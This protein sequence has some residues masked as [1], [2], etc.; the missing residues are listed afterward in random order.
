MLPQRSQ[1]ELNFRL[2]DHHVHVSLFPIGESLQAVLICLRF[3]FSRAFSGQQCG[4]F[5]ALP[6]A[7]QPS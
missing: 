3:L 5:R 6:A 4:C 1:R 7:A 2:L